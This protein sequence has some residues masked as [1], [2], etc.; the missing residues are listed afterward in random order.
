MFAALDLVAHPPV[1]L[2]VAEVALHI[3]E[4]RGQPV[5]DLLVEGLAGAPDRVGRVLA[6]VVQRPVVDGDA[7]D[8]AAQQAPCARAGTSDRK[9][10]TLARSPVI[11]KITSTS[12]GGGVVDGS[13]AEVATNMTVRIRRR[14]DFLPTG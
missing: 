6:Q 3:G 10:I 14:L 5:E 4:T 11:P 13:F 8:R 1:R 2:V 12:P 9:V 7:D